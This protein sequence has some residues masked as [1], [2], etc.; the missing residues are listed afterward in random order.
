M[1]CAKNNNNNNNMQTNMNFTTLQFLR[2]LTAKYL[3]F[4]P[5]CTQP[6]H[7]IPL[8]WT[9]IVNQIKVLCIST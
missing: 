4:S 2:L 7:V 5:L 1:S 9:V 3:F 6:L 8:H